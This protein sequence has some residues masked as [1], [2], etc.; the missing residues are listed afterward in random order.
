MIK[1]LITES[2]NY[3]KEAIVI[4][5]S[6]GRVYKKNLTY[7]NLLKEIFKYDVIVTKLGINFDK[8]ILSKASKLKIIASPTTGLDHLDQDYLKK[9]KG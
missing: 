4:L 7:Q 2:Q 6:T 5:E 8:T 9:K 3:S 1:I